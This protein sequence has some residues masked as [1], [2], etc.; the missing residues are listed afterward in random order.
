[1]THVYLI[2]HARPAATWG[3]ALDPGLDDIGRAQAGAAAR[4]LHEAMA[5]TPV[6]TSPLN[7]CRETAAPLSNL[8]GRDAA[9][10]E[11][12][13]EIPSPPLGLAEKQRWLHAAMQGTWPE[14]Q[15]TAPSGSPDYLAWRERL[16]RELT[17]FDHDCVIFTHYIAI[18]VAVGAA[19]GHDRVL[20]FKPNHASIT[21]IEIANSRIKVCELGEEA[22]DG[23]VLLGR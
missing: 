5:P 4:K 6:Y 18:N 19:Q 15:A 22:A 20:S 1:M 2:R 23:S 10:F 16:I 7:R 3:E 12:V 17:S 8:W 13:A 11:A 21:H 9:I 14:L